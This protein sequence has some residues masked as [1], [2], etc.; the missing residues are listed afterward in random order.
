M[1]N[2]NITNTLI[3]KQLTA[4]AWEDMYEKEGT[5][6]GATMS[7]LEKQRFYMPFTLYGRCPTNVMLLYWVVEMLLEVP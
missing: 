3:N 5:Y 4:I 7:S 6:F 2:I 1:Q